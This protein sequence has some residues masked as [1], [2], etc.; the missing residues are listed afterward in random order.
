MKPFIKWNI[1]GYVLIQLIGII[2]ASFHLNALSEAMTTTR[3][4]ELKE[5]HFLD[6]NTLV[7]VPFNSTVESIKFESG[8][9]QVKFNNKLGWLRAMSLKGS[10]GVEVSTLSKLE[11]GRSGQ[12]NS[13][14][15]TGVRSLA[16]SSRHA[17]IIGVGQYS[18]PN[19]QALAGVGN[20]VESAHKMAINMLIPEENIQYLRD[21]DASALNIENEISKLET[22][23][24]NGDRVFIYYS[25]HGTRWPDAESNGS[26]TE[27]L[28]ASDGQALSNKQM[29]LLLS[30]IAKKT[31]KMMVFYDACHSGGIV[32]QPFKTRSLMVNTSVLSPKFSSAGTSEN[33]SRPSNMKTRSLTGEL[34]KEGVIAENVVF[35]AASR[36]D[37]VSF[38]DSKK[39]GLA[40]TAW[41]DCFL[42]EAKDLDQSG[43]ISVEEI[44]SCAQ[45]KVDSNLSK[46]PEILGQKMTI[47]G[48]KGFIPA[49]F[50]QGFDIQPEV[51]LASLQTQTTTNP[52]V[53]L[54]S[55][56]DTHSNTP[57]HIDADKLLGS[58][59][60]SGYEKNLQNSK[61]VVSNNVTHPTFQVPET[62]KPIVQNSAASRPMVEATPISNISIEPTIAKPNTKPVLPAQILKQIYD[63]RDASR[64]LKV[65]LSQSTLRINRDPLQFSVT[66][67]NEGY[68]YVALAGSDQ[69]SLYLIYPN[70]IDSNNQIQAN[71]TIS[72]PRSKWKITAGG[73]KGTD[74]L[75]VLVTDSP[76]D[77]SQLV[78]EREGPFLKSLLS[79]EGKSQLQNLLNNSEN[80]D[81]KIC[82]T[83]G[84]TRNLKVSVVCSDA[85]SAQI[86]QIEEN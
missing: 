16:K 14:S 2:S 79:K 83:G 10:S 9:V 61:P 20:D 52:M 4:T 40:T 58:T 1:S 51:S 82:Q 26:C 18:A 17:L 50:T 41:R 73:P 35:I 23:V 42:G 70:E 24:K 74:T 62:F 47:G 59:S 19:I 84:N 13:M 28:L 37:E 15:T 72:L 77:I 69:K 6:A 3:D 48:N 68:V 11:T 5:D 22:R 53:S 34:N 54:G 67:K 25:G 56:N 65:T 86:M 39:G 21:K 43:S 85:F 49:F 76:R 30:P 57:S 63:Q 60:E 46:Y 27:G 78:S 8:W 66:S 80:A 44:T 7:K 38:D 71:Q 32:N 75:L 81:Q 29:S 64:D 36:P 45:A 55:V 12:K 33:C 31:D